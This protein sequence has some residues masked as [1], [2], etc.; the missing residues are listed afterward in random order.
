M[1]KV[2]LQSNL[3]ALSAE[4]RLS[5]A[6]ANVSQSLTRLSSGLRIN[7]ASDDAAGLAVV[8]GLTNSSRVLGQAL[9]NINDGSS[10][11]TVAES[12]IGELTNITS[13][14]SE[15]ANQ[16]ASSVLSSSQRNAL[17][18][19]AQALSDEYSR[20][21][22]STTFNGRSLFDHTFGTLGVA[23]G[24][25]GSSS[26]VITSGLGG[27]VG[28]GA[29]GGVTAYT[30]SN[31]VKGTQA[32]DLN[33]DGILDLVAITADHQIQAMLGNGNGTFQTS[34]SIGQT[35]VNPQ[36][37]E[38]SDFNGDGVADLV[39][40]DSN[41]A[42]LSVFIGRG[43][44]TFQTRRSYSVGTYNTGLQA[45]DINN[46]GKI[47]L[48]SADE[49]SNQITTY[50]GNGDGTFGS[51]ATIFVGATPGDVASADFNGDGKVDLLVPNAGENAL[52]LLFGNGDGTFQS[53]IT[54][55]LPGDGYFASVGDLNK[56]G[57][58]D[59]VV[60]TYGTDGASIFLGGTTGLTSLATYT[61]VGPNE[62]KL[63]DV[64]GDSALDLI[65]G[66]FNNGRATI[67]LGN[68]DGTFGSATS[69]AVGT[70]TYGITVRDMNNDGAVDVIASNLTSTSV[71]V[72][73][74]TRR[75]GIATLESFS[76]KSRFEALQASVQL[77]K[78]AERLN[79]QRGTLGSFQSRLNFADA[80][81]KSFAS[82]YTE[83]SSR[84][85]DIDVAREVSELLRNQILQQSA[86]ALAAQANQTSQLVLGLLG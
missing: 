58:A 68:G 53:R 31:Q 55:G 62:V 74:G 6:T 59:V 78:V 40:A 71:G 39:T 73:L 60:G 17:D 47:D 35:G 13:R 2:T 46:D 37:L 8:M 34:Y 79:V 7:R 86:T 65:A 21:V 75:D 32:L 67:S 26:S 54:Y 20:V 9:S 44:G 15:L 3:A 4:R 51:R 63:A 69:F 19:E 22:R 85:S 29:F 30:L 36:I 24:K 50:L 27:G 43:D 81:T 76:L 83:A 28:D 64:N 56:D 48:I 10:L 57:I 18:K 14:L 42:V 72:I 41:D 38:V 11:L 16:A 49:G 70:G 61:D 33:N 66:D 45:T 5:V 82:A 77:S 80:T 23:A 52:N 84:I 1:S 12:A 25:D